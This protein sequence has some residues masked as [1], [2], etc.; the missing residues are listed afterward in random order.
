MNQREIDEAAIR[1]AAA[2]CLTILLPLKPH[3]RN[4]ALA[5]AQDEMHL[6]DQLTHEA[7]N[8]EHEAGGA[9]GI[10]WISGRPTSTDLS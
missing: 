7:I 9:E 5:L 6:Q 2:K 8:R 3:H 4:H 10:T 1:D